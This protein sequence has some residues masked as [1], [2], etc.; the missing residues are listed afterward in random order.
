MFDRET[1]RSRGFGFVTSVNP[2]STIKHT[3]TARKSN[4]AIRQTNFSFLTF[5]LQWHWGGFIL[6][7]R[8]AIYIADGKPW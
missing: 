4:V 3:M 7:G 1:R 2:V 6:I 5:S 8:F